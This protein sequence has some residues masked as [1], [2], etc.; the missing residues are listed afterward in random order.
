MVGRRAPPPRALAA[1]SQHPAAA[2]THGCLPTYASQHLLPLTKRRCDI[3]RVR[4][5][6][7]EQASA[8]HA[9]DRRG[10]QAPHLLGF[11]LRHAKSRE[12]R[13]PALPGLTLQVSEGGN[14]T[15]RLFG[16]SLLCEICLSRWQRW[17]RLLLSRVL[18][19]CRAQCG[20][21]F[22][23]PAS[24]WSSDPRRRRRTNP[25]SVVAPWAGLGGQQLGGQVSP[26]L[27]PA[28]AHR[29]SSRREP[30]A[31]LEVHGGGQRLLRQHEHGVGP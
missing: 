3:T 27:A 7:C 22:C 16:G 8:R 21:S 13:F 17:R 10:G 9:G 14:N 12:L 29:R 30:P 2:A 23:S 1:R 15:R 26:R 25:F 24:A 31:E 6:L 20:R 28:A 19:G 18:P 5:E 11:A 4:G